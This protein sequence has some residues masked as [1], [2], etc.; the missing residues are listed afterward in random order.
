MAWYATGTIS[1]TNGSTSVTGSGT[2]F[3]SGAQPGEGLLVAGALYEIQSIISAT[4][5][6]LSRPYLGGTQGGVEFAVVPTQSVAAVLASGVS[7][8]MAQFQSVVDKAGSGKFDDGTVE[9]P[10]IKFNN[11]QNTGMYRKSP[12]SFGLV[13]GGRE[14]VGISATGMEVTGAANF[15]GT[16]TMGGLT[17][18]GN[19]GIGSG[20]AYSPLS[21]LNG[22]DISMG[23]GATGQFNITGNGYGFGIALNAAGSHL[24]TNSASRPLIFG[25]NE[26]ER[27]RI[28]GSGNVLIGTTSTDPNST[29]GAQLSANGRILATVDGG[30]AGYFNRLTSDGELIRLEKQGVDVGSIGTQ[31]GSLYVGGTNRGIRFDSTQIIPVDMTAS[32][33]NANNAIDIGNSGVRFKDLFIGNVDIKKDLIVGGGIQLG[34]TGAAN[35]LDQYEEGTFSPY[36]GTWRGAAPTT[37]SRAVL[38]GSYTKIGRSV[39]CQINISSLILTG[40]TSGLLVIKGLPFT[41]AYLSSGTQFQSGALGAVTRLKFARKD[42]TAFSIISTVG[43]GI[44]STNNEGNYAWEKNSIVLGASIIRG[45]ITYFTDS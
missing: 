42:N 7:N 45:S 23:A 31:S 29:A 19:V 37:D 25:V 18:G 14:I 36:I 9:S 13:A 12:D 24:Y 17:V 30:N 16:A 4:E 38:L 10:G 6:T 15:S 8:L 27:M 39:T 43:V 40:T 1:V 26:I 21:I 22:T 3:I 41:P 2:Q 20:T 5:L 32:G 28:D 35:T 44:E 34:G 33:A 11:D